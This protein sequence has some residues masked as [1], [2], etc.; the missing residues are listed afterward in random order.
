MLKPYGQTIT[1]SPS[2]FNEE[3]RESGLIVPYRGGSMQLS[4]GNVIEVGPDVKGDLEALDT[5]IY[6][7]CEAVKIHDVVVVPEGAVI[8][9]DKGDQ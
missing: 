8:A 7:E 2:V 6:H 9:V 3:T 5:V 1:V 4:K